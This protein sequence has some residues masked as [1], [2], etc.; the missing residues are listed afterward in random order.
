[1]VGTP[2]LRCSSSDQDAGWCCWGAGIFGSTAYTGS[3][4]RGTTG[5]TRSKLKSCW[6]SKL[7]VVVVVGTVVVVVAVGTVVVASTGEAKGTMVE[8]WVARVAF[9]LSTNSG[10]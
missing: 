7:D 3:G 1:M 8:G 5:S 9:N 4:L 10:L 2:P 6:S